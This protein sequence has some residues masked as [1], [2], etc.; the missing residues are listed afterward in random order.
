MP[1]GDVLSSQITFVSNGEFEQL[2]QVVPSQ[3]AGLPPLALLEAARLAIPF[4]SG[5]LVISSL[6]ILENIAS[7]NDAFTLPVSAV[8]PEVW[9]AL[10]TAIPSQGSRLSSIVASSPA[11]STARVSVSGNSSPMDDSPTNTPLPLFLEASSSIEPPPLNNEDNPIW[12]SSGDETPHDNG[13]AFTDRMRSF[14]VDH[15]P[16][17][18]N[19]SP[20]HTTSHHADSRMS[21][22]RAMINVMNSQDGFLDALLTSDT[23]FNNADNAVKCT[24]EELN[25]GVEGYSH[26]F[27]TEQLTICDEPAIEIVS[28]HL[29]H[30]LD[31]AGATLSMGPRNEHDG[32][33]WRMLRPSDWYRAS[34]F[35]LA[36]VLRGCVCTPR[37]A[38][39]GNFPLLPLQDSFI[40][41]NNLPELE[42]Q[43]DALRAMAMQILENLQVDNGLLMPQ[44]SVDGIRSTVWRS[45]EAH[46]RAIVEQEALKV[47]HRLS[48][49]GLS[50]LINKLERDAPIEEITEVLKDDIA[51][52]VRSKH[53]NAIL[54]IK[55]N[56]YKQAVAEAEQKGREQAAKETVP[57]EARLLETAK[58]QAR[59]K[60][61][62]EFT[63][64]LA[65]ERSKIA[66]KVDAEIADE[67]ARF[68]A[69]RRKTL[70]AQLDS[71]SLD[72]EKEFV[73]AAATRLGLALG[74]TD[75]PS[76]KVKLDTCKPRPAPITP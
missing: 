51:E 7:H 65:D 13:Q 15:T 44:D 10:R 67:H 24:L 47:A 62:S 14:S 38:K 72:A 3:P 16:G 71:L 4:L 63:R 39:L 57:Y 40:Y 18:Y 36:S 35:I 75:Q 6:G 9:A 22:T 34:T 41:S 1:L 29:R 43:A 74:S 31:I 58:E 23:M 45:H 20:V 70:V 55:S 69:D 64:L 48:T 61:N 66:P 60:A 53:N 68:I 26:Y 56:A 12:V 33:I 11:F 46:I 42:T 54:V 73:L 8:P 52:Q 2:R 30:I 59:L 50:D 21:S 25:E 28:P 49:M 37:V 19:P 5:D 32:D 27:L 17:P 76:K